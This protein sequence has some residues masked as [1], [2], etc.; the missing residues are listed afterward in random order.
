M[1]QE[2]RDNLREDIQKD[3]KEDQQ[4]EVVLIGAVADLKVVAVADAK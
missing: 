1:E 2:Q 4:H 3:P